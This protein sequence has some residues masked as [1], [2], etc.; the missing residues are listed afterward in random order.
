MPANGFKLG[1][2]TVKF[3][4]PPIHRARPSVLVLTM[5]QPGLA[6]LA[7]TRFRHSLEGQVVRT[8]V[9]KVN[10]VGLMGSLSSK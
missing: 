1:L 8:E 10:L 5:Q 7:T 3:S 2:P 6:R 9:D 4:E